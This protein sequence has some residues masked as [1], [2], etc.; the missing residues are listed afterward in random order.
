MELNTRYQNALL[1]V[2]YAF[3]MREWAAILLSATIAG[4]I[5]RVTAGASPLIF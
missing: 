3:R 4:M 1:S 5:V 2:G